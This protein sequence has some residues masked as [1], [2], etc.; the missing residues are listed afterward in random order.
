MQDFVRHTNLFH[1]TDIFLSQEAP[2]QILNRIGNTGQSADGP[3]ELHLHSD[4]LLG[5]P[6]YSALFKDCSEVPLWT[7]L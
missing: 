3:D 7:V 5:T 1:F 4:A 6:L 2:Y